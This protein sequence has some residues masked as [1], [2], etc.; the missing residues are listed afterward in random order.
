MTYFYFIFTYG[1]WPRLL[2]LTFQLILTDVKEKT[3]HQTSAF[4]YKWGF[5]LYFLQTGLEILLQ[6]YG[7]SFSN[8]IIEQNLDNVYRSKDLGQ[9]GIFPKFSIVGNLNAHYQIAVSSDAVKRS[10]TSRNLKTLS[11]PP[12]L[13]DRTI[14]TSLLCLQGFFRNV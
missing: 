11:V 10:S 14:W 4:C 1:I 6:K 5:S 7:L 8:L 2:I 13:D 9:N 3:N 12:S